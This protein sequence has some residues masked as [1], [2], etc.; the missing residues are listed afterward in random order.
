MRLAGGV[1]RAGD[2]PA[3]GPLV[4]AGVD[5]IDVTATSTD[6]FALNHSGYAEKSALLND[7]QLIIQ[8]GERPPEK[9]VPILERVQTPKGDYWRYPSMR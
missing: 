6:F 8:T 1:P 9:R 5:T 3:T 7:I 4:V 2:V